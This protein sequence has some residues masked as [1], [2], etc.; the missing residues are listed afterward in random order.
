MAPLCF[1]AGHQVGIII[2][3]ICFKLPA[4]VDDRTLPWGS[5]VRPNWPRRPSQRLWREY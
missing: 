3:T 2:R 4:T 1:A 5:C